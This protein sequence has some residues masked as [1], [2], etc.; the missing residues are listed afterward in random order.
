MI[1]KYSEL[2]RTRED[3]LFVK[4]LCSTSSMCGLTFDT[5]VTFLMYLCDIW[6]IFR[7]VMGINE[8]VKV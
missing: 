8:L 5:A 1:S 3:D 2:N 4:W 7:D 6:F